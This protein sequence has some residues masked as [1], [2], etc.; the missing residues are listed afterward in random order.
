MGNT[1]GGEE[2][3]EGEEGRNMK[4]GG[5]GGA[6]G[7]ENRGEG[8]AKG[9]TKT[10]ACLLGCDKGH[11]Q[12]GTGEGEDC[13]C[14]PGLS[15]CSSYCPSYPHTHL[16]IYHP[17]Y[18]LNMVVRILTDKRIP[19]QT[20][21]CKRTLYSCHP[22]EPTALPIHRLSQARTRPRPCQTSYC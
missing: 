12:R 1:G 15:C 18:H 3:R 22:L 9:G 20:P 11:G 6:R 5:G 8:G 10:G 19:T 16:S 17:Y 14:T 21:T 4:G 13:L 7:V 2:D